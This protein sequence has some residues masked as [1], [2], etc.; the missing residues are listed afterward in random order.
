MAKTMKHFTILEINDTNEIS[1]VGT[2]QNISKKVQECF[3]E[4][5]QELLNSHFDDDVV[6]PS[7]NI[8]FFDNANLS[9]PTE[10]RIDVTID[11]ETYS[12]TIMETWFSKKF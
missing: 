12:I 10:W 2:I 8:N 3:W 6:I 1:M 5:L 11:E 7:N 4:E 9:F